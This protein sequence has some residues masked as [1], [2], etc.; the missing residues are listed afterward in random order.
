F[1]VNRSLSE[2]VELTLDLRD[3]AGYRPKSY[4][5]LTAGSL[6]TTNTANEPWNVLPMVLPLPDF[7]QGIASPVLPPHSWNVLVF[8]KE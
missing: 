5:I 3:F 1:A 8:G 7:D 4:H 6:K 2:D